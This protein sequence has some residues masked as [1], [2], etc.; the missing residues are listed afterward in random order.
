MLFTVGYNEPSLIFLAGTNTR[1]G[2]PE[3]AAAFLAENPACHLAAIDAAFWDKFHTALDDSPVLELAEVKGLNY[4]K[5][6][7]M[8]L[9][10]VTSAKP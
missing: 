2:Q 7:N 5:G 10:L 6:R 3:E 4:A 8:D 9:K 1:Y